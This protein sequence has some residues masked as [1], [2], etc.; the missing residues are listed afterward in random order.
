M[1]ITEQFKTEIYENYRKKVFGYIVSKIN[2]GDLAEE[3]CEDVF[4][5]VYDNLESFDEAKASISTW[6][7]T[8][9]RNTLTDYYR[10][11]K[12]HEEIPEDLEDS[13]SIEEDICNREML[14]NLADALEKL[15]ERSRDIVV[16]RYYSGLTMKKIAERMNISYSYVQLLHNNALKDMKKYM[17]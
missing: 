14:K 2:N 17:E 12:V 16:L 15:D 1:I 7:Y 9:A 6:I 11:R 5:K 3:L 4:L 8:I 10:T 13:Y